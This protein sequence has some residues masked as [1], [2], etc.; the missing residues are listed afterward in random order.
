VENLRLLV[1]EYIEGPKVAGR[2]LH[3]QD[4]MMVVAFVALF[5]G[6]MR[7]DEA[8]LTMEH[9]ECMGLG[10]DGLGPEF[11]ELFVPKSKTDQRWQGL[12]LRIEGT[13][14]QL[15]PAGLLRVC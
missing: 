9:E 10:T 6:F 15:C 7:Y 2:P 4:V 14:G 1:R 13:G 11:V 8:A 3:L 12:V 5:A